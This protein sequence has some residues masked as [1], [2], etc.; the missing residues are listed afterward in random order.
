MRRYLTTTLPYVND[1]PHIGH[2]L[3]FVQAD[4]YARTLRASGDEVF[5]NT[6]TDEHG[7]KIWKM[8]NEAGQA[9]QAYADRFASEFKKLHALLGISYD[10]FIRT[11]DAGHVAAATEFWKRCA[12]AG[13]IYKK[14]YQVKYCMGCELE[15]TDSELS[16]GRCAL[17][18]NIELELRDE[19][20]YFFRFSKYEDALSKLYRDHSELVIPSFR[21]NEFTS[22]MEKDGLQDF[23]ISRLK[24]KMPWG[25]P[26]PGDEDQVMYVWF[27]A[28]VSY[29]STLGWPETEQFDQFWTGKAI[30]FAGK[31]QVRQQAAMWQ[32]MLLSAGLPPTG[33]IF[34]HGFVTSNGQ[35]MSKSL[36]NTIDPVE[37]AEKYGVD[38]FRYF[39]LRHVHPSEDSDF[40]RERFEE[41]Y[42]ANLSNGLG[43]LVAR[44]MKLAEDNFTAPVTLTEEDV[45]IEPA[46][47]EHIEKF[48]F[49]EAMDLIWEHIGKGDAFMT[50]HEPYKK[51]KSED[52]AAK[53]EGR[54]EIEKLVRHIAKVAA[55]LAPVLPKTSEAVMKAVRENK[56]PE[57][58]FPR[59]A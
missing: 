56:K 59:L 18:P 57:N 44:V 9:P 47:I 45:A 54:F 55:H 17:H 19:E 40:T 21:L 12:A 58:L 10:A 43:N 31:D 22:L 41:A 35:K 29:I 8:A 1:K 14:A 11:T 37:Y 27:D 6:G 13:D 32:A 23:S 20:N 53:A 24:S 52:E 4:A 28:L 39:V 25:V 49:N 26:V 3:E 2:A 34:I 16:N 7:S 30:Q 33:Q 15:K 5:F 51:V 36:G 50:E 48:R 38:A 46:F 42:I